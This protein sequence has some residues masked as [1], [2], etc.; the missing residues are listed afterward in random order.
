M[1]DIEIIS[2]LK[3]TLSKKRFQHSL[4]VADE[5]KKLALHYQ[6]SVEK[7]YIAGL[8][9]DIKKEEEPSEMK[10]LALKCDT[11]MEEVEAETLAL[12]HAPASAHYAKSE[13][14]IN[15]D[16]VLGAIRW[17]TAGKPEM[18]LTEIIV[19]LADLISADRDYKDVDF[20][21]KIAY[22]DKDYAMY[23]GMKYAIDD[24]TKKD[25]KLAISSVLAYNYYQKYNKKEIL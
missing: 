23:I 4:N 24:V 15:D 25:G 7:C 8:L 6:G 12:W 10:E 21:R 18:N 22:S 14:G 1:N 20:M 5:A 13:L 16:E 17:H 9:H 3:E 11:I 2:L 19:Y